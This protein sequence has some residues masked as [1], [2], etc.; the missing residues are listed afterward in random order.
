MNI[1]RSV[2]VV[3][4]MSLVTIALRILPF[5]VFGGKK[6]TPKMI[7]YLGKVLPPAVMAMLVIYCLKDT[8]FSAVSGFIPQLIAA[9]VVVLSYLWKKNSLI[10]IV[11]GT[12]VFMIIIRL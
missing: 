6:E 8:S 4:I 5:V 2:L 1:D 11:L 3:L 10:S 7:A 12:A 9:A